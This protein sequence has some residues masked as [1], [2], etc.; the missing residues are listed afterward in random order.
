MIQRSARFF[1]PKTISGLDIAL[2]CNEVLGTPG[3]VNY[4][5]GEFYIKTLDKV[6]PQRDYY[7]MYAKKSFYI[8]SKRLPEDMYDLRER[9]AHYRQIED[10][11]IF[12]AETLIHD[13]ERKF[14]QN[15]SNA[16]N[17]LSAHK[18]MYERYKN[19]VVSEG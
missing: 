4:R 5:S 6:I 18:E 15:Y 1:D 10:I 14:Q 19:D 9:T 3:E 8:F 2:K 13:G 7:S 11:F 17:E 12:V 16:E